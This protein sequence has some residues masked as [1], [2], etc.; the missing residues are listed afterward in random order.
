MIKSFY[1]G[2][3]IYLDEKDFMWKY[4]DNN[5]LIMNNKRNCAVCGKPKPIRKPY[6]ACIGKLP[7]NIELIKCGYGCIEDAEVRFKDG[8]TARGKDAMGVINVLIKEEII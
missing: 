5:E 3:E 8:H 6:D 2:H 4:S 7:K 1:N